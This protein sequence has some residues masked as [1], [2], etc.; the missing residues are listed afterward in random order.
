M[1]DRY[2][3]F[4]NPI[5]HSKSPQIHAMFAEQTAQDLVYRAQLVDEKRFT[6]VPYVG[7][8]WRQSVLKVRVF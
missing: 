5:K 7:L 6:N 2:A 3:V 4:G 1:T 8:V